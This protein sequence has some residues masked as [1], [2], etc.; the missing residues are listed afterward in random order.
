MK[1]NKNMTL[2]VICG[3]SKVIKLKS[4]K[5]ILFNSNKKTSRKQIT[6][7]KLYREEEK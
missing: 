5:N 4:N 6:Y 1:N 7:M 3:Q 2:G